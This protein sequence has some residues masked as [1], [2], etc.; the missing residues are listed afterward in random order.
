MSV[1]GGYKY[2]DFTGCI[3]TKDAVTSTETTNI[4]KATRAGIYESVETTY[5]KCLRIGGLVLNGQ[6]IDEQNV[7]RTISDGSAITVTLFVQ[8]SVLLAEITPSDTTFQSAIISIA[9]NDEITI[10]VTGS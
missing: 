10:T 6:D 8:S 2:I 4:Y 3:F 1:K 7:N 9:N 5:G